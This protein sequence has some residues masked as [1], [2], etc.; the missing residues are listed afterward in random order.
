M[1]L[2]YDAR[3]ICSGAL[4]AVWLLGLW[5]GAP[6][7]AQS[8]TLA[9]RAAATLALGCAIPLALAFAGLLY[10]WSLWAAL[11]A[12]LA[13][14]LV[15]RREVRV[16]PDPP[17]AMPWDLVI[18]FAALLALAWPVA[19]RPTMDGD[20]FIYHLPNAASW[21]AHHGIWTTGTRYWW[22]PPASEIFASGVLATGGIGVVGFAGLLPA[23]LLLLTIRGAAQRNGMPPI[24]GTLAACA[25]LATP[26]AAVQ[27]VSLQNDLWLAALFAYALTEVTPPVFGV[28]ALTKPTGP[29]YALVASATWAADRGT[30]LRAAAF[31][32]GAIALWAIRDLI[33]RPHAIVPMATSTFPNGWMSTTIAGHL[34]HSLAVLAASSWNAGLVWTV[35]FA[36]GVASIVFSREAS[37]RWAALT[38]LVLFA[39]MP[40]GYENAIPQ[41]A[42]GASLRFGL[43]LAALG[44][45]WLT[46][47]PRRTATLLAC[48][49]ALALV[50]GV[51]VQWR[52]FY[53]DSTTHA[54]PIVVAIA[55]LV[56]S[57]SLFVPVR[58]A[59]TVV[60]AALFVVLA[61][62]AGGLARNH[63][64]DYVADA[65]G[66][67]GAFAYVTSAHMPRVVTLGLPAGAVITVDPDIDA[68][69]GTDEGTCARARA[70]DAVI[71]TSVDRLDSVDCGR[72]LYRDAAT[73]VVDPSDGRTLRAGPR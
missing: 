47:M 59:R 25:L 13:I 20:T 66:K 21:V 26:V 17:E 23:A 60:G 18:G 49:A 30:F 73:A 27:L 5:F 54:T 16:P 63:P 57:L 50:A 38:S 64:A 52:L 9:G 71:V 35:F 46:A 68:Y 7:L 19:V 15:Q 12:L 51:G 72:V 14:R 10:W 4:G 1:H 44:L 48:A 67:G 29:L 32:L 41:L 62:F 33:L 58:Q 53:N 56:L 65:Y 55:V 31:S 24:A 28:L 37:L 22:Y 11:V 43:P 8:R 45:L 2:P 39:I 61:G 69:D 6:P 36:L 42:T 40:T 70:L 3:A 34:P